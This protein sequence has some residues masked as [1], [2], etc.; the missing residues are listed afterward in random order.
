MIIFILNGRARLSLLGQAWPP[1][2]GT[3]Q[4]RELPRRPPRHAERPSA[5]A[6]ELRAPV[7]VGGKLQMREATSAAATTMTTAFGGARGVRE[8]W[9]DDASFVRFM[10]DDR[11]ARTTI[12]V[13]EPQ[14]TVRQGAAW[15]WV[16][17]ADC[18]RQGGPHG[19]ILRET[20]LGV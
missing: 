2:G 5:A 14:S 9:G 15:A 10:L 18:E 1:G 3:T 11:A 4:P 6:A 20:S 13:G 8:G 16:P 12:K 19:E 17:A 7:V